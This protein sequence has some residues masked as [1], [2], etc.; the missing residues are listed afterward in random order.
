MAVHAFAWH[1]PANPSSGPQVRRYPITAVAVVKGDP[2]KI[3]SAGRALLAVD[4]ETGPFALFNAAGVATLDTLVSVNILTLGDL[5]TASASAAGAT[6]T[7]TRSDVGLRC[8]WIK[9]TVSG[10][11]AKSVLDTSDT[12]TPAWEIVDVYDAVGTVDGRYIARLIAD[13]VMRGA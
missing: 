12:T 13:P 8:S 11:T 4:T 7:V 2:A 3:N 10:E 9:S 5:V 6:R 1:K